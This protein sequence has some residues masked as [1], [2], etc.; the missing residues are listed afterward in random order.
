MREIRQEEIQILED[1]TVFLENWSPPNRLTFELATLWT[2]KLSECLLEGGRSGPGI[3]ALQLRLV[4]L[5]SRSLPTD[6]KEPCLPCSSCL[7][8]NS[9]T[10]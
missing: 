7:S 6:G 5:G 9:T 2:R 8:R 4:K 1:L 10:V 3:T